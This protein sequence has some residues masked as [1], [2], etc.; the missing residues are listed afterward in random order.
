M[1]PA[2]LLLWTGLNFQHGNKLEL[3]E[4]RLVCWKV[5][6]GFSHG[7]LI[8]SI[9]SNSKMIRKPQVYQWRETVTW[10]SKPCKTHSPIAN[11]HELEILAQSMMTS[12]KI[13]LTIFR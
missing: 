4:F 2:R 9:N 5:L 3:S 1:L 13:Y 6:R 10:C 12:L 11:V 7:A 8:L